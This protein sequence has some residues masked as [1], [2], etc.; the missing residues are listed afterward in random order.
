MRK[1]ILSALLLSSALLYAQ[2][3]EKP[4][5][6]QHLKPYGYV[7]AYAAFDTR[8]GHAVL[9]DFFYYMPLD[10]QIV[11][12]VDVNA[13]PSFRMAAIA[14]RLGLDFH[15]FPIGADYSIG[16]KIEVDFNAGLSG[17]TGTALLRLRHAYFTIGNA[18]H[19]WL[20]GQT[21][22]PMA[23]DLPGTISQDA[24][25]PFAPFARSPQLRADVTLN[26]DARDVEHGRWLLSAALLWQMQYASPGPNGVS[27][28]YIKYSCTPEAY[29]GLSYEGK[30][31]TARLGAE[32]VSLKPYKLLSDRHTTF[33]AF[34]YAKQVAH[35]WTFAQKLTYFGDGSNFN[36][37]GGYGITATHADGTHTYAG[38]RSVAAWVVASYKA[39]LSRPDDAKQRGFLL[40]MVFVGY[41]HGL[42]TAKPVTGAYWCKNNADRVANLVR[43]QPSLS[44]QLPLSYGSLIFGLEYMLTA[45]QYGAHDDHLLVVDHLHWVMNHRLQA[46]AKYSF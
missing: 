14:T 19:K 29:L 38:M 44:Y 11:D 20:I 40:P 26:K 30:V 1:S 45:A 18:R 43:F 5:F 7:A 12:G 25:T 35:S 46:I 24:G 27:A 6:L 10:E 17:N 41:Q 32:V 2:T 37:M 42:G 36:D 15:D 39:A 34:A 23:A 28:E 8:E 22:H 4:K 16:A 9:D 13:V 21:W 33:N 3:A 31:A